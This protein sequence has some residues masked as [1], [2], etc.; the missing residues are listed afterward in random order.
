MFFR[1]GRHT[2]KRTKKRLLVGT[3]HLLLL[4]HEIILDNSC[5]VPMEVDNWWRSPTRIKHS[6]K[7][8]I[9]KSSPTAGIIPQGSDGPG[10]Q[11]NHSKVWRKLAQ[12]PK[13]QHQTTRLFTLAQ[14]E[15]D[16]FSQNTLSGVLLKQDYGKSN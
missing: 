12:I 10:A 15:F 3:K 5:I 7:N 11:T 1:I 4:Q 16:T 9:S 14:H 8:E 6:Y 2:V 13:R